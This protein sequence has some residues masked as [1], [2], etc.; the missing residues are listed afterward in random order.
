MSALLVLALRGAPANAQAV[1]PETEPKKHFVSTSLFMLANL[2]PLDDPPHFYQLNYGYR[3]TPKDALIVEAITWRYQAPLGIPYG[4]HQGDPDEAF[5]GH[6]RD[7]G[8]GLAY[9][10]FI[11]KGVY[12]ALHATPFVQTY[13]DARGEKIQTGFQL[14][15]TLRFGYSFRLFDDRIFLEPSVAFTYWPVNTNLPASFQK[16]EDKWPNYF[17]FEPGLNLGVNL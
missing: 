4:T 9:Q 6:V 13:F 12:S 3:V 7:V 14:F 11:W 8:V 16:Q 10:R 1:E 15:M 5:P 2:L 17:L